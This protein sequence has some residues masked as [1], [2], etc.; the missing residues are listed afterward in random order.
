[1]PQVHYSPYYGP[2]LA[3]TINL[4]TPQ[5]PQTIIDLV[6]D[7]V[8]WKETGAN[9][10]NLTDKSSAKDDQ[11]RVFR[12]YARNQYRHTSFGLSANGDPVLAFRV[13]GNGDIMIVCL[14]TKHEMFGLRTRTQ[15]K[16]SHQGQFPRN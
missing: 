2:S 3:R 15:F 10:T 1:M 8:K 12:P 7:F 5:H 13:L 16:S 9:P 11:G 14:T 6:A 4:Y